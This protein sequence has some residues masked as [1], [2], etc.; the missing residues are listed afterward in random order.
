MITSSSSSTYTSIL[1]NPP[2]LQYKPLT[3]F[4]TTGT[5]PT[6]IHRIQYP[7]SIPLPT[8]APPSPSPPIHR[9]QYSFSIPLPTHAPP[10][11]PSPSLH[12]FLLSP[13]PSHILFPFK[14]P[15]SPSTPLSTAPPSPFS[16]PLPPPSP[17]SPPDPPIQF[18]HPSQS[19][20][21]PSPAP[22]CPPLT[23]NIPPPPSPAPQSPPLQYM[24]PHRCP[25]LH[26]P[27][28]PCQLS[29]TS[30]PISSSPPSPTLPPPPSLPFSTPL[31]F[32]LLLR[33]HFLPFSLKAH[34]PPPPHSHH[35]FPALPPNPC[36]TPPFP[37]SSSQL[38][39]TSTA[40][41]SASNSTAT[42]S[43]LATPA[44]PFQPFPPS[45]HIHNC[46]YKLQPIPCLEFSLIMLMEGPVQPSTWVL[47]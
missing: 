11:P 36:S 44:P 4:P 24:P 6:P 31:K 10:H 8:H 29:P 34:A 17:F 39:S 35:S 47:N 32:S 37:T 20:P 15:S 18:S 41:S 12:P 14:L 38:T 42:P 33:T 27:Q 28:L 1:H 45:M 16:G 26:L 23:P 13:L 46:D 3:Q 9:I 25:P 2:L 22:Q 7:C 19:P 5:P 21:P 40:S 43:I 30:P